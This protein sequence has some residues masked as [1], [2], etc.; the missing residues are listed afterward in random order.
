MEGGGFLTNRLR[1][2]LTNTAQCRL[3]GNEKYNHRITNVVKATR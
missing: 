3:Y 1:K 2:V